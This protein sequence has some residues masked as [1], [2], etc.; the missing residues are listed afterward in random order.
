[1]LKTILIGFGNIAA[2][3]AKDKAMSKIIE[4]S[5]HV[6]VLK[7]HPNYYLNTVVDI[8]ENKLIEARDSWGIKEVVNNINNLKNPDEFEIAVIAI[9]PN[10]RLEIINKLPNLKAIILEKPIAE[11]IKEALEIIQICKTRNI[12]VQVNFPRRFDK[13]ILESL[14]NFQNNVGNLQAAFGLYGNGLHNNGSHLIDWARMFMGEV[15]WVQSIANGKSFSNGPLLNDINLPFILGFE[16]NNILIVEALEFKIYREILLDFWGEKGRLFFSQE[17]LFS[18][19]CKKDLHR[20]SEN[21]YE[22]KSDKPILKLMDQSYALY[23]LYTNLSDSIIN[24]SILKSDIL[25]AFLVL[26]II[27]KIKK[28]FMHNNKKVFINE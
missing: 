4:Y 19:Y 13:K 3:Y 26:K 22:I 12:L 16:S 7:E 10:G 1:M 20:Y 28:S 18:S 9:P 25:N 6:K 21:D 23:H 24:K 14:D 2:G 8:D 11:N 15:K 17:G 27:S 5:T